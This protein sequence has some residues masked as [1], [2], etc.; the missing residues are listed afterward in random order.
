MDFNQYLE[1]IKKTEKDILDSFKDISQ[2]QVKE[3]LV[4]REIEKKEK[5]EVSPE[6]IEKEV[7][8]LLKN[9]PKE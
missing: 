6:E 9:S 8:N 2:K 3:S 1:K 5:I 4:L 7:N